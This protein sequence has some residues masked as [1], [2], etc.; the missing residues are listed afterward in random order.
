VLYSGG[1]TG[2]HTPS[3]ASI[4]QVQEGSVLYSGGSTGQHTPSLASRVQ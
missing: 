1:S 2:Q 4:Y 3:L